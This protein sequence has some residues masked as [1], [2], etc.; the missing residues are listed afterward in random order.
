MPGEQLK[1]LAT[2]CVLNLIKECEATME[3]DL[4][5][6]KKGIRSYGPMDK[7][8]F[9]FDCVDQPHETIM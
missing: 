3:K 6:Q 8:P 1:Q 5:E 4:V 9:N 2:K 7:D